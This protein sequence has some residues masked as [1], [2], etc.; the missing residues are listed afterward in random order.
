MPIWIWLLSIGAMLHY[1]WNYFFKKEVIQEPVPVVE[2]T[3]NIHQPP[4]KKKIQRGITTK[5]KEYTHFLADVGSVSL[6]E[7]EEEEYVIL[8]Y[9]K[10][11]DTIRKNLIESLYELNP[12]ISHSYIMEHWSQLDMMYGMI[13]KK[14]GEFMGC[15]AVDRKNFY[16]FLSHLYVHPVYRNQGVGERFLLFAEEITKSFGFREVKLWCKK[17]LI[18]YYT[19]FGWE[20]ENTTKDAQGEETWV[21]QK[22]I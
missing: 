9:V 3:P 22:K 17:E 5:S 14:T 13:H 12:E 4:V 21:M 15:M 10:L 19:K 18:G 2:V 6:L 8:P 7:V 1:L 20:V 16:P 11:P